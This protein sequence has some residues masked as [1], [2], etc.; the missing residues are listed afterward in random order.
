MAGYGNG[1][2]LIGLAGTD[3]KLMSGK[4]TPAGVTT[5]DVQDA[6]GN[7]AEQGSYASGP[8]PVLECVYELQ[9]STLNLNTLKLG[10]IGTKA[11]AT[12][13]IYEI[14]VNPTNGAWPKLTARAM[15]ISAGQGTDMPTFTLPSVTISGKK[16][17]QAMLFTIGSDCR[18]TSATLK[19]GGT[20]SH[21]LAGTAVN[22][23]AFT[24]ATLEVTGQ[25][26]EVEG[27]VT[28]TPDVS[29]T[30]T[31]PPGAENANTAWGTTSF[32]ARAI[33]VPDGE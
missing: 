22:A 15:T 29:L 31:Q 12:K 33:I 30:E 21:T 2:D 6:D 28:W 8:G 19:V 13:C 18:L 25:A 26:T 16:Q 32:S 14:E 1:T 9:S 10:P 3:L 24:G 7:M 27:A 23:I 20:I 5:V 17:A 4:S 11:T